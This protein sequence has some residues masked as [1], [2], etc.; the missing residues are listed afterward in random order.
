MTFSSLKTDADFKKVYNRGK[1]FGNRQLVMYYLPNNLEECRV[2][3]SISKKVGKANVR[4]KYRR[5]LKEIVK[6]SPIET[7]F[8]DI[9]IIVRKGQEMADFHELKKSFDHLLYKTEL[10]KKRDN[11]KKKHLR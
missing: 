10:S 9:I 3:F 1:S 11:S 8:Y 4:N 7:G 6:I 2:G 5:R